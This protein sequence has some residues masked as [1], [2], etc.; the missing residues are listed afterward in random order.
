MFSFVILCGL[1]NS[2]K[3]QIDSIQLEINATKWSKFNPYIVCNNTV[4]SNSTHNKLKGTSHQQRTWSNNSGT[5]IN[6]GNTT[7]LLDGQY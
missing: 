4:P 5:Y 1:C 7:A 2:S 3:W 6:L